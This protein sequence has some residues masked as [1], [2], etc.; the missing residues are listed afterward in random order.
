MR[1]KSHLLFKTK[2]K[3]WKKSESPTVQNKSEN[4]EKSDTTFNKNQNKSENL[5]IP[6]DKKSPSVQNKSENLKKSESPTVQNRNENLELLFSENTV[7]LD[8]IVTKLLPHF[9]L[10]SNLNFVKEK[11]PETFQAK[12]N[13]ITEDHISLL[14]KH[15]SISLLLTWNSSYSTHLSITPLHII[16]SN[17][18]IE[19]GTGFFTIWKGKAALVTAK[20]N[21]ENRKHFFLSFF[22]PLDNG[23]D[24]VLLKRG[25]IKKEISKLIIYAHKSRDMIV[26]P[27]EKN[28]YE[29]VIVCKDNEKNIKATLSVQTL[30]NLPIKIRKKILPDTELTCFQ[31]GYPNGHMDEYLC[32]IGRRMAP[33]FP[34]AL[35]RNESSFDGM[36][37]CS[38]DYGDS[39]G[40]LVLFLRTK[41]GIIPFVFGMVT[42]GV[43][44][45]KL[46]QFQSIERLEEI[47]EIWKDN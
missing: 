42:K 1:K 35:D 12:T 32:A 8:V 13:K 33:C 3:F 14:K 5:S 43:T 26:I 41:I 23:S 31:Y 39:G 19:L 16:D 17:D 40:P 21:L 36:I 15:R 22:V 28:F 27:F 38:I 47:D 44:N 4:L 18:I 37:D 25:T 30:L 10:T 46:A 29:V 20:H 34:L 9:I 7:F 24:Q 6:Q 45:Q 2:A 11:E